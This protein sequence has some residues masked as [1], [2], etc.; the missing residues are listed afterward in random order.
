[1]PCGWFVILYRDS[2]GVDPSTG[3]AVGSSFDVPP[4]QA[5]KTIDSVLRAGRSR[6]GLVA[7]TTLLVTD[8]SNFA[9]L[10]HLFA[11]LFQ[12]NPPA[13]MVMQV[14]VPKGLLI[15]IGCIAAAGRAF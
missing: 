1:M 2:Q 5:S 11:E 3:E 6:L 13:L 7:N 10:N 12:N 15:S 8:V 14:P 9:G 4:R